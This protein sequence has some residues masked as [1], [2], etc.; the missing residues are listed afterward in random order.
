MSSCTIPSAFTTCLNGFKCPPLLST[1]RA[2]IR[3]NEYR[4]VCAQLGNPTIV[5]KSASYPSSI[6][7]HD[8]LQSLGSGYTDELKRGDVWKSIQCY[9][10]ETGVSEELAREHIKDLMRQ[11]WKKVNAYRANKDSPLSQ[12]T[13]DFMLNLVRASHFM[14]L[15]GDGH[16]V[17]NQ[18]TMDVAF[19]LL[20][21]PI[22]L[23]DEDMVFTPSLGTKG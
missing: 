1:N 19:T 4:P 10:H 20:F 7:D 2:T 8:F 17:Q 12:T 5:R 3:V 15:H 16:G 9:M 18:E 23:E 14:Y 21:R 6:W 13:A 11:M 22:P